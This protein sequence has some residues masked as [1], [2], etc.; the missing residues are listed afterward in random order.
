MIFDLL[1]KDDMF[2]R[3]PPSSGLVQIISAFTNYLQ[4]FVFCFFDAFGIPLR[5][6]FNWSSVFELK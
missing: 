1:S 6:H 5:L 4:L 2:R 3:R